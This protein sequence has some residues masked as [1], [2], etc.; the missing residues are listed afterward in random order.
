MIGW[1]P[2]FGSSLL[3]TEL[4]RCTTLSIARQTRHIRGSMAGRP[5][6][7]HGTRG[8]GNCEMVIGPCHGLKALSSP[9]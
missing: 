9:R 2:S 3:M 6:T 1:K 8:F 4:R 7:P 5:T